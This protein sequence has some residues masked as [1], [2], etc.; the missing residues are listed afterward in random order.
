MS[1]LQTKNNIQESFDITLKDTN[2]EGLVM[3]FT[4]ISI[5]SLLDDGVLRSV[6]IVATLVNLL[7]FG[8]NIH[9]KLFGEKILSF[10]SGLKNVSPRKR[11]NMIEAIDKSKKH[12]VKVGKKLLYII[13]SCSDFENSERVAY[14]FKGVIEEKISYD[15]LLKTANVLAKTTSTDFKWFVKNARNYM[16]VE[17]VGSLVGS[18]LFDLYYNPIYISVDEEDDYK[19]LLEGGR[20]Y[21]AD[22]DGGDV[23]VTIS[24]AGEVIMELFNP[25]YEKP[26][27]TKK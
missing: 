1:Y 15:D 16:R 20:K 14:V 5:D 6:P 11:K 22:I 27:T 3:D 7:K 25:E 17:D 9:D 18:G 8:A 2:L 24:R 26:K 19:T 21:K 23:R 4:E 12:R 13:D 10:L